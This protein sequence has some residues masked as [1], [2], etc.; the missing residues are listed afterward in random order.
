M[1]QT[2][3]PCYHHQETMRDEETCL[4]AFSPAGRQQDKVSY[5]LLLSGSVFFHCPMLPLGLSTEFKFTPKGRLLR[6]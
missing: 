5:L 1:K 4:M 2:S 6:K 3:L